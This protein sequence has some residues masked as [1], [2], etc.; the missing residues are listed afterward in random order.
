[1]NRAKELSLRSSPSV[2]ELGP[3]GASAVA[4]VR[5]LKAMLS[6]LPE[7]P[8]MEDMLS[9]SIVRCDDVGMVSGRYDCRNHRVSRPLSTLSPADFKRVGPLDRGYWINGLEAAKDGRPLARREVMSDFRVTFH[10]F[11]ADV[12]CP[13]SFLHILCTPGGA[14]MSSMV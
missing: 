1:M 4:T 8:L 2:S 13:T 3:D 12:P 9:G 10:R 6:L 11:V 5:S 14:R 7:S